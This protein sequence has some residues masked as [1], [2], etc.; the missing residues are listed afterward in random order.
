M[1][2]ISVLKQYLVV[3]QFSVFYLSPRS[4]LTRTDQTGINTGSD[5]TVRAM[6]SCTSYLQI[7]NK[8]FFF[9]VGSNS[10]SLKEHQ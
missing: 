4:K 9:S 3:G 1:Y 8:N 7:S 2:L 5:Q 6:H 10:I